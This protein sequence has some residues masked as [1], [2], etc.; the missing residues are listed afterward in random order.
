MGGIFY[1]V[2]GFVLLLR[3][4]ITA[5]LS[6]ARARRRYDTRGCLFVYCVVISQHTPLL[7]LARFA[8]P[9]LLR[10]LRARSGPDSGSDDA[11]M[12]S[13]ICRGVPVRG[14]EG[15]VPFA[16]G[17]ERCHPRAVRSSPVALVRH[18]CTFPVYR[19][20]SFT[21]LCPLLPSLSTAPHRRRC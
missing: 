19:I 14:T 12:S 2:S 17:G 9:P 5:C 3:V 8:R 1:I 4:V 13:T 11:T 21:S 16:P 18:P 15:G 7:R 6:H 20:A 10:A